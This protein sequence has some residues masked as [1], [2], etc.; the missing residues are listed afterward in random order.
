MDPIERYVRR[1]ARE[2]AEKAIL[3]ERERQRSDA[4]VTTQLREAR[5]EFMGDLEEWV[6]KRSPDY[7]HTF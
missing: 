6:K 7:G 1:I 2:E 4:D 5:D 3:A